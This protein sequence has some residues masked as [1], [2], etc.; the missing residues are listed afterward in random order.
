MKATLIIEHLQ[1]LSEPGFADKM[2]HFGIE[3]GKALGIRM[4]ALRAYAKELGPNQEIA[5]QLWE[6]EIHEAKLMAILLLDRKQLSEALMDRWAPG[7]YS[8]DMVDQFCIRFAKTPWSMDKALAWSYQEPEYIKRAGFVLMVAIS[9]HDKGRPDQ[10][11]IPFFE[12]MEAEAWDGRNFVKKAVNWALRAFG[13]RS[14]F[15]HPLAV[16]CAERIHA[17]GSGPAKWIA[18]DALRELG[19]D[20]IM[21]RLRKKAGL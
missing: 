21:E 4:P 14:L 16:A 11:L 8:W 5:E 6:V 10:D 13:K 17:Q 20:K 7:F 9:V 19:G 1:S 3:S 15:L 12:R 2:G 18:N